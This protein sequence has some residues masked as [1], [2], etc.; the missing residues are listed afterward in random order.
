MSTPSAI[1]TFLTE[2]KVAKL[3]N[4]N[5]TKDFFARDT[6]LPGFGLRVSPNNAKSYFVE[7]TIGGRFIRK[8]VA[9]HPLQSVIEAR[10]RA[11]EA[12]QTIRQGNGANGSLDAPNPRLSDLS[13]VFLLDKRKVL[14]AATIADYSRVLNGEYFG[15]GRNSPAYAT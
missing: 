8:V 6:A 13:E 4:P 12:L 2:T 10:K 11:L 14:R 7:A 15:A 9:K 3:K 1:H 5:S